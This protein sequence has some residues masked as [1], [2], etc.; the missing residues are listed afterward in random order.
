MMYSCAP[1]S[2]G[3]RKVVRK[4]GKSLCV[5]IHCHYLNTEVAARVAQLDPAQ[6]DPLVKFAN[7]LTRETNVKQM[8]QRAR[9]LSSIE[10]RL[11]DMDRMAWTSRPSRRRRTR[12]TTG[13]TP[14]RAPSS[15]AR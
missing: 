6:H 8:Q 14:G 13:P 9:K 4:R 7:A 15:R 10:V 3:S 2:P 11:K 1:A 5:D 12:P